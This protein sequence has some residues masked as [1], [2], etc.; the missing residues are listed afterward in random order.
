[1]CSN[2]ISY[3]VIKIT[4]DNFGTPEALKAFKLS[5]K[6][7]TLEATASKAAA[8]KVLSGEGLMTKNGK[9]TKRGNAIQKILKKEPA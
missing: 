8:I 7:F 1:M 5:A 2:D 3:S 6:R 9:L 4:R